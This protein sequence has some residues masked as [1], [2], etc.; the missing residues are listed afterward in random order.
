MSDLCY[1][2]RHKH[3]QLKEI[4][5]EIGNAYC[6]WKEQCNGCKGFVYLKHLRQELSETRKMWLSQTCYVLQRQ[7]V[8]F[9]VK[10]NKERARATSNLE[11]IHACRIHTQNIYIKI[12]S[13]K[14]SDTLMFYFVHF[15]LH[16]YFWNRKNCSKIYAF[17]D[18][19]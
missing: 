14:F 1:P 16:F 10:N 19:W 5:L 9:A 8:S 18:Y 12:M 6:K 2:L 3:N 15:C 11:W 7:Q 4:S 17:A 13:C